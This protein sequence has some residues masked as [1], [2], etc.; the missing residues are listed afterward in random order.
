MIRR[1]G[2]LADIPDNLSFF[3][4]FNL[5]VLYKTK[6][7]LFTFPYKAYLMFVL[8]NSPSLPVSRVAR[9]LAN[10]LQVDLASQLIDLAKEYTPL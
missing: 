6:S 3:L 8:K 9:K 10:W 1:G 2:N 5:I 4:H 7:Q